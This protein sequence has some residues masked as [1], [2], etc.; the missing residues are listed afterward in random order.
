MDLPHI[1]HFS[2]CLKCFKIKNKMQWFLPVLS[3]HGNLLQGCNVI[4]L[5]TKEY[6]D[7]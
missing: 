3:E 4:L 2:T 5:K 1:A 7:V 6:C